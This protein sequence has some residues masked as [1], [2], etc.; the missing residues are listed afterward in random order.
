MPKLVSLFITDTLNKK[1]F[2]IVKHLHPSLIFT[3]ISTDL[4]VVLRP[5]K[6]SQRICICISFGK[7]FILTALCKFEFLAGSV[8]VHKCESSNRLK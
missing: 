4:S 6:A 2:I 1:V 7:S 5:V 8:F 3:G